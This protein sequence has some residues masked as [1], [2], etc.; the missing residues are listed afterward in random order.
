MPG[1]FKL[2]FDGYAAS[3]QIDPLRPDSGISI[4]DPRFSVL[5]TTSNALNE[6]F[7]EQGLDQLQLRSPFTAINTLP[8]I[9][10]S[11]FPSPAD[12]SNAATDPP[13]QT[14]AAEGTPQPSTFRFFCVSCPEVFTNERGMTRHEEVVHEHQMKFSCDHCEKI[15]YRKDSFNLHHKAKHRDEVCSCAEKSREELPKK[16]AYSCGNCGVY[17]AD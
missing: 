17:L 14:V 7:T 8:N 10:Y 12:F 16:S 3:I 1:S 6:Q 5:S 9:N 11:T 2:T 4:G 15:Y 13:S